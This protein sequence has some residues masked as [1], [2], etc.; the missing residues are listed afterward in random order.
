MVFTSESTTEFASVNESGSESESG[1]VTTW[2]W[3]APSKLTGVAPTPRGGH[4]AT[5]VEDLLVV[6][7]GCFLDKICFNDVTAFDTTHNQW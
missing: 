6:F 7:G 2:S 4:S 5:A 3:T 1:N